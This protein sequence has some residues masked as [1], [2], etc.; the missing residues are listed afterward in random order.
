MASRL[1]WICTWSIPRVD[2]RPQT[3][4]MPS[5]VVNTVIW[6]HFI[7]RWV[8]FLQIGKDNAFSYSASILKHFSLWGKPLAVA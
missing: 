5:W 1:S 2:N 6:V 7:I 4:S 8:P 3:G